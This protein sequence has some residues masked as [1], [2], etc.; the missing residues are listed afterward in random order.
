[1]PEGT[2]SLALIVDDPDA[3]SGMWVHWIVWDI[4]FTH[5]IKEDHIPGKEGINDFK[6]HHYGGPCPPPGT[7][8]YFFKVYALD[9]IPVLPE[10]ADK[11]QLEKAISE[12]I[13][14]FGE[15]VGLYK[16]GK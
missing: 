3:P 15:L 12:H 1:I 13:V 5:H 10:N 4:P 6:R 14:G 9:F 2:K 8:R 16:R 11:L 7:H